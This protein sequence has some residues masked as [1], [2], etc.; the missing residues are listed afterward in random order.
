MHVIYE[1]FINNKKKR[2]FFNY[3]QYFLQKLASD[4]AS[5][6]PIYEEFKKKEC[7]LTNSDINLLKNS[8]IKNRCLR[9]KE[10]KN[11]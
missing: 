1:N 5:K 2:I 7:L 8:V 11:K 4:H 3:A 6:N 9:K 10:Q